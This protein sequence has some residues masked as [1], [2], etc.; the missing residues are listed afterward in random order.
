MNWE[1]AQVDPTFLCP[2]GLTRS[3][4]GDGGGD[5]VGA[6]GWRRGRRSLPHAPLERLDGLCSWPMGAPTYDP[7]TLAAYFQPVHD[8][9]WE[10]PIVGPV[11]RRLL[12][13][14][15]E[16][17]DAVAD[18][19]RSLIDDALTKTPADRLAGALRM[20]AF[21]ERTRGALGRAD[22]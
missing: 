12:Q 10:D 6:A 5:E 16:V 7:S 2:M 17:I 1:N 8:E 20:A 19:D 15:P 21:I 4:G 18:V 11:L 22:R 13:E 3:G 9:T 14:A